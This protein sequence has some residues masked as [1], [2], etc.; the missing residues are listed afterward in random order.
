MLKYYTS[1]NFIQPQPQPLTPTPTP[2]SRSPSKEKPQPQEDKKR[3]SNGKFISKKK[4]EI[5]KKAEE[6]KIPNVIQKIKKDKWDTSYRLI[7]IDMPYQIN[8]PNWRKKYQIKIYFQKNGKICAKT[9][10]FGDIEKDDY[11]DHQDEKRREKLVKTMRCF[12]TPFQSNYWRFH[13]LNT[14][15]NIYDAYSNYCKDNKL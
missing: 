5:D 14:Y 4:I 12:D 3:D 6:D 2:K 8:N 10:R 9:I 15:K 11:I 7:K 1:K 13:M